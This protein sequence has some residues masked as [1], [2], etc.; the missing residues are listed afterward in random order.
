MKGSP[1]SHKVNPAIDM[2]KI[3][4]K[5]CQEVIENSGIG[6]NTIKL[7][8]KA[9]DAITKIDEAN[10]AIHEFRNYK[11]AIADIPPAS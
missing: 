9:S 6:S 4:A 11:S 5:E 1:V 2:E 8:L 10:R 7:Q 3:I